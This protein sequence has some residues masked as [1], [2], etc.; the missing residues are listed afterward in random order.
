MK[1][2]WQQ[3]KKI[4]PDHLGHSKLVHAHECKRCE[5]KFVWDIHL[6]EHTISAHGGGNFTCHICKISYDSESGLEAHIESV[7]EVVN[8]KKCLLCKNEFTHKSDFKRH[9]FAVHEGKE[10]RKCI[11][12]QK[13]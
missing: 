7:R 1:W 9:V 4:N 12:C 5:K 3:V 10:P 6:K 2:K 11:N 8:Q 13:N